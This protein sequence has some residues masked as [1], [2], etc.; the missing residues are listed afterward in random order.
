MSKSSVNKI[1]AGRVSKR[2]G[3]VSTKKKSTIPLNSD[4]QLL[5]NHPPSWHNVEGG[6]IKLFLGKMMNIII[7]V[8]RHAL[9]DRKEWR[10]SGIEGSPRTRTGI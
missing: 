6:V 4:E 2:T 1:I 10:R 9:S 8:G 3:A 5:Q 7:C